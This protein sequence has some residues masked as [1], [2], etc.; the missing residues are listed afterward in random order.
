[1]ADRAFFDLFNK[2][3][4]EEFPH[5]FR[6]AKV[7]NVKIQREHRI[8]IGTLILDQFISYSDLEES[9]SRIQYIYQLQQL[10]QKQIM[11]TN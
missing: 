5:A 6:F 4:I 7:T 9:L 10:S 11:I 3:N 1:M 8:L 2:L